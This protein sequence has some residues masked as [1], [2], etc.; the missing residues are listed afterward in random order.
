MTHGYLY[1]FSNVSM[2]GILKIGISEKTPDTILNESNKSD[3]WRPPTPYEIQFAKKII[4]PKEKLSILH[5]YKHLKEKNLKMDFFQVSIEEIK[6]FFDII[7]GELWNKDLENKEKNNYCRD[8]RKCFKNGQV[9]RHNIG[10][11][12]WTGIYNLRK[13][14]IIYDKKSY[15]SLSGFTQA[16][17]DKDRKDRTKNSNGWKE[18]QYEVNGEWVSTFNIKR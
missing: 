8:M 11:S 9:I 6:P 1:C 13:N 12:T 4:K 2:P 14:V 5:K 17:Y 3:S 18:C 10:I 15:K 16:H 7:D